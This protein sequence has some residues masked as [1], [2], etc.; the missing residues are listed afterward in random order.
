MEEYKYYKFISVPSWHSYDRTA[1]RI[2][3]VLLSLT[4]LYLTHGSLSQIPTTV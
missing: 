2:P 4:N 1:E 3:A